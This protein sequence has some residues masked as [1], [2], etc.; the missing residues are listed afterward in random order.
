MHL[1]NLPTRDFGVGWCGTWTWIFA[2]VDPDRTRAAARR[3]CAAA[4]AFG[5]RSGTWARMERRPPCVV[6]HRARER[7]NNGR[8]ALTQT[9][10]RKRPSHR[11]RGARDVGVAASLQRSQTIQR[12]QRC[13]YRHLQLMTQLQ[14]C[15][16]PVWLKRHLSEWMHL[17]KSMLSGWFLWVESNRCE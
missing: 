6:R 9:A 17:Y 11:L 13:G 7:N 1:P 15:I 4:E 12:L 2:V 8:Y 10:A 14:D 5:G 16:E 3:W